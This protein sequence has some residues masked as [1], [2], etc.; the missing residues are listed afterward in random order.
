MLAP[1]ARFALRHRLLVLLTWIGV[2]IAGFGVGTGV[3]DRLTGDV[4]YVDSSESAA[5]QRALTQAA[6]SGKS[7][8]AVV[9]G[10]DVQDPGLR[11]SVTAA[12][13]ALTAL[14]NVAGVLQP[15]GKNGV[16]DLIAHDGRALVIA[17]HLKPGHQPGGSVDTVVHL[18]REQHRHPPAVGDRPRRAGDVRP[19]VRLHR[20]AADPG[21]GPATDAARAGDHAAARHVELVGACAAAGAAHPARCVRQSGSTRASGRLLDGILRATAAPSGCAC[22]GWPGRARRA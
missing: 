18:L 13:T 15:Y 1:L 6:P 4:G 22:C 11:T 20:V 16:R 8:Y 19:A 3:F 21:Q 7:I 17:V 2:L 5:G 10:R 12:A 9:D 14:P